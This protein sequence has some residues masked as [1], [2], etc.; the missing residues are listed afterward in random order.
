[1]QDRGAREGSRQWRHVALGEVKALIHVDGVARVALFLKLLEGL[2]AGGPETDPAEGVAALFVTESRPA[3]RRLR[4]AGEEVIRLSPRRRRPDA[5]LRRLYARSLCG[6][7]GALP[8]GL[9]AGYHAEIGALLA[10]ARPDVIWCWNGTKFI[11]RCLAASG[12]PLRA[13]ETANIAGHFVIEEGGTNAESGTF[14]ALGSGAAP[15]PPEGFDYAAWRRAWLA[16][17]ERPGAP[18]Q[19][20]LTGDDLAEKLGQLL[21]P[22]RMT[23]R[24][25]AFSA[26]RAL[27]YLLKRPVTAALAALGKAR[28]RGGRAPGRLTYLPQQ[29]SSDSQLLFHAA[30][31]NRSALRLAL[32]QLPRGGALVSNLHPAEHRLSQMLAFGWM[33]LREPRL[34]PAAGP[35]W[36]LLTRAEE[37]VTINSTVGLE[38]GILGRPCRFLGRSLFER[39]LAEPALLT[40][41]LGA[42]IV[43][44]AAAEARPLPE[45]IR[46]RLLPDALR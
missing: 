25:I 31:D 18:P 12:L 6:R 17:K 21:T 34:I 38:A 44:L 4:A 27:G 10:A 35:S 29:V 9:A 8:P 1:M 13:L 2:R 19:A 15:P 22:W 16:G 24:Y 23:P 3:A 28:E 40:W 41:Y 33:A 30:H 5:E 45:A 46:R 39:L 32:C 20:R 7:L 42:H 36:P 26:D 37:V 14:R 43:P 11:D